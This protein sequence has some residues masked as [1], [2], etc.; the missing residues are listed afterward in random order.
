[1]RDAC[2]EASARAEIG[3]RDRQ[4][5]VPIPF[6]APSPRH[7]SFTS[8]KGR[9]DR[10][11][12][13]IFDS[14][15]RRKRQG[16]LGCTTPRQAVR[17]QPRPGPLDALLDARSQAESAA[18]QKLVEPPR[19]ARPSMATARVT[20]SGVLQSA[21]AFLALSGKDGSMLWNYVAELDGPGGPKPDGLDLTVRD[22]QLTRAS[23]TI[24]VPTF[25]DVD[26]DGTQDLIASI[27]FAESGQETALDERRQD[28]RES[29]R[30]TIDRAVAAS[31][32]RSPAD[33][34]AGSGVT[35]STRLSLTFLKR[36]GRDPPRWCKA[37]DRHW[38]RWWMRTQWP[39]LDPATGRP[40][41]G[42]FMGF[43][44][45]RPLQHA[46][47]DG[48]GD[49]EI[50]ALGL[51]PPPGGRML[52]AFSTT[53][54]RELWN[55]NIGRTYNQSQ[56]FDPVSESPLVVDLDGDGRSEI[57]AADSGPMPPL[58]G[59]RGVQL[60]DGLTG[61]VRWHRPMRPNT[62]AADGLA[63]VI[64]APD[65]DGDGTRDLVTVSLFEGK[66]S[67]DGPPDA[68]GGTRSVSMSTP[69]REK[70]G[71][72]FWWWSV[73]LPGA[74]IFTRI[75]TPMLVGPRP[76]RLAAASAPARR[77]TPLGD[78]KSPSVQLHPSAGGSRARGLHRERTAHRHGARKAEPRRSERR[79]PWP[80]SWG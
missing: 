74:G 63:G 30:T 71:R 17:C 41:A 55:A 7:S 9:L 11:V 52:G 27:V 65:L 57:V 36:P 25:A 31:W 64:V 76:R 22:T 10:V 40:L 77:E 6:R 12:E 42:P 58:S 1:M 60:L 39:G 68:A 4:R 62:R 14:S 8:G 34:D 59:Y 56:D 23:N 67:V 2:S 48:D 20:C 44:P 21:S 53:T 75:W 79:R 72:P 70:D 51:G 69:S 46:D 73:E 49:P 78:G 13:G 54:G 35:R 43:A 66:N 18:S 3:G 37:R 80:T 5:E 45:V 19:G 28:H 24:G 32:W 26:R 29:P 50:L 15:R 33:P 61:K 47:L 38:W 16:T